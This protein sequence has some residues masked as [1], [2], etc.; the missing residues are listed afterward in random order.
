VTD[1]IGIEE[2]VPGEPA[3]GVEGPA[4]EGGEIESGMAG[5]LVAQ[6]GVDELVAEVCPEGS[7]GML[8]TVSTGAPALS[9][10][11]RQLNRS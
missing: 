4:G 8:C 5:V 1:G 6:H 3:R 7:E 10:S 11:V 9:S 2:E